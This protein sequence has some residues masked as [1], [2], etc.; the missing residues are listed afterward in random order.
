MLDILLEV[1]T[2]H[3]GK[4]AYFIESSES[5]V[6][7]SVLFDWV[8]EVFEKNLSNLF[9]SRPY[10]EP[11]VKI[12]LEWYQRR[13]RLYWLIVIQN[14]VDRDD[15][16]ETARYFLVK[17]ERR[18]YVG[19]EIRVNCWFGWRRNNDLCCRRRLFSSGCKRD[20]ENLCGSVSFCWYRAEVLLKLV[21]IVL[22]FLL[23]GLEIFF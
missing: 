5:F 11:F 23:F 14:F 12:M 8:Q 4:S 10:D 13:F 19:Q 1:F 17:R 9:R 22:F 6:L 15:W 21:D 18:D 2:S 16:D 20:V 3:R 7:V